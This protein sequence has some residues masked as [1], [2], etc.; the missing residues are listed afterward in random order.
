V[1]TLIFSPVAMNSGTDTVAPVSTVAGFVPPV[2]RSPCR[3]GS[4]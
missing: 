1:S 2:E 4:V 3:P